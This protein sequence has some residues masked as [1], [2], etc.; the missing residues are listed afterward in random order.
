MG[1][2]SKVHSKGCFAKKCYV[3]HRRMPKI[4]HFPYR[5]EIPQSGIMKVSVRKTLSA[6]KA[7]KDTAL[8]LLNVW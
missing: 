5:F 8:E 6:S 4:R 3:S 7:V 2:T 1:S